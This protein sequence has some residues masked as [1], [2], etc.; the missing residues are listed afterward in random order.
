VLGA[1]LWGIE[2]GVGLVVVNPMVTQISFGC[3]MISIAK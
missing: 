3:H 1:G 2:K